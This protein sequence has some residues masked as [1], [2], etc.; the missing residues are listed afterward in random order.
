[1]TAVETSA[2]ELFGS[3]VGGVSAC[4]AGSCPGHHARLFSW[5][6]KG[7]RRFFVI[8]ALQHHYV[9][10]SVAGSSLAGQARI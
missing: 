5:C 2:M 6:F 3:T 8:T 1:M 4:W 7:E 10:Q 9:L